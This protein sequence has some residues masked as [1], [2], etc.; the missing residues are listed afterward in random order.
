MDDYEIAIARRKMLEC[1]FWKTHTKGDGK[2]VSKLDPEECDECKYRF[3]CLTTKARRFKLV[4]SRATWD[5][6][7]V[8]AG[9]E[10]E[11]EELWDEWGSDEPSI[12]REVK[13]DGGDGD[14]EV[15][16]YG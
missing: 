13:S 3:A 4:H 10:E 1:Q 12:I 6:Y 5:T 8:Y 11:A 2:E 15:E 9:T 16:E 14:L 7:E